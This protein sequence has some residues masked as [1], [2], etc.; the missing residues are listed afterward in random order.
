MK[1]YFYKKHSATS[2]GGRWK[3]EFIGPAFYS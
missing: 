1:F 3:D 2:D